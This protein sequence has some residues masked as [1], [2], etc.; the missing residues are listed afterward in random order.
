MEGKSDCDPLRIKYEE[1]DYYKVGRIFL[2]VSAENFLGGNRLPSC[3][4]FTTDR[5]IEH[6]SGH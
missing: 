3:T 1:E 5:Y 2:N 4:E 6:R